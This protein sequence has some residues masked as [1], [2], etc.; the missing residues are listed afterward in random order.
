MLMSECVASTNWLVSSGS[1]SCYPA[2]IVK[3]CS[4]IKNV[5]H[6]STKQHGG[7]KSG[8]SQS[9]KSTISQVVCAG[10]LSCWKV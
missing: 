6:I 2:S 9:K 3:S 7:I 5:H 4:L 8:I 1:V 10:A